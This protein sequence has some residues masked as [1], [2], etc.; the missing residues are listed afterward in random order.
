ML[1]TIQIV[2][3]VLLDVLLLQKI[4]DHLRDLQEKRKMRKEQDMFHMP[5]SALFKG[6]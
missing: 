6:E 5:P 4:A 2:T 3:L 1:E